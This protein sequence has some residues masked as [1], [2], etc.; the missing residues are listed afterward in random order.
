MS[1]YN[2]TVQTRVTHETH[3]THRIQ[4]LQKTIRS[5]VDQ[6]TL[7]N[8]P[9]YLLVVLIPYLTIIYRTYLLSKGYVRLDYI[10]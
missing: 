2:K 1:F 3:T 9:T 7:R 4:S 5:Y 6:L 8:L 10:G